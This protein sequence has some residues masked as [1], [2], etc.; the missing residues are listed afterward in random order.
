MEQGKTYKDFGY[1][2]NLIKGNIFK[3]GSSESW[4][5]IPF[6]ALSAHVISTMLNATTDIVFSATDAD[7][8]EWTTGKVYF[9]NGSETSVIAA[10]NTG[11]MVLTTYIYFDRTKTD[12]LQ[13]TTDASFAT[14]LER[15]CLAKAISGLSSNL[16][17]LI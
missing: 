8:V 14:G 11:N 4:K 6:G 16:I 3:G 15:I 1:N 2:D 17:V 7:T 13:I 9:A 12:I 5:N 10:G